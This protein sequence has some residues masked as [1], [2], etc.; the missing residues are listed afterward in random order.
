MSLEKENI[1]QDNVPDHIAVIMDGNGRWAKQ[2]GAERIFGHQNAVQS[3][4]E[5]TE[6]CVE[7]GIPFLTLYAFSTENWE[8][9]KEEVDGLMH[10]LVATLQEEVD[11]LIKNGVKLKVIGEM[12]NLPEEC[13][14]KLVESSDRTKGNDKLLLTLALSYSGKWD[15]TNALKNIVKDVVEGN[16]EQR[17][18]SE[19]LVSNYL[20]TKDIPDPALLIRTGGEMR[21]SNFLLWQLAYSELYI[22]DTMWPDFRKEHLHE[23]IVSYQK[24]ERRFGRISDQLNLKA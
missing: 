17:E 4:K 15:I 9:P 2:K 7:L 10:L 22:T 12:D 5:I 20:S 19:D 6:G 8:R 3:V 11:D 13:Q 18:I 14:V 16:L 21:L 23:A 24:R 1:E